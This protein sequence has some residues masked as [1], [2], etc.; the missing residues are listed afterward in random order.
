M[1][2]IDNDKDDTLDLEEGFKNALL[3]H[4]S[5]VDGTII[6]GEDSGRLQPRTLIDCTMPHLKKKICETEFETVDNPVQWTEFTFS[7][8]STNGGGIYKIH[9]IPTGVMPLP[10]DIS[11]TRQINGWE[12]H[13]Y[14]WDDVVGPHRNPVYDSKK[15]PPERKVYLDK[16]VLRKLGLTKHKMVVQDALFFYQILPS[17]CDGKNYGI[18][19]DPRRT[20]SVILNIHLLT[21]HLTL[22]S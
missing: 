2:E 9:A 17:I 5:E 1:G 11:G 10:Q 12:S 13:Y 19:D 7:P 21:T 8:V 4:Q 3:Q 6:F 15:F 16:D 14:D 18:V 22:E 20:T